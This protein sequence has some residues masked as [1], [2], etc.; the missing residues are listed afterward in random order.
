VQEVSRRAGLKVEDLLR[1][2]AATKEEEMVNR[3]R[4][5]LSVPQQKGLKRG[6]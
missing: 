2:E 5:K 4:E 1:K 3:D 6:L